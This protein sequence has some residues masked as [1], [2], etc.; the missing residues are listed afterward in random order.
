MSFVDPAKVSPDF[1]KLLHE[2]EHSRVLELH[3]PAGA[4]DV[5]HAHPT[6]HVV[7]FIKGGKVRMHVPGG[8]PIDLDPPDGF[9]LPHEPWTHRVE[10][11][12][13][14]ELHVIIFERKG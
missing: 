8:D 13:T 9:L 11:I 3:L 12:G 1:Y 6:H 14:N 4:S 7:Y 2:D 10:N 5:E